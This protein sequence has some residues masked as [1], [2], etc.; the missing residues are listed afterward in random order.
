MWA[1]EKW[2]WISWSILQIF[3]P[4]EFGFS[5]ALY[6]F[7]GWQDYLIS[8][9]FD[10]FKNS[11][12]LSSFED[13]SDRM[14]HFLLKKAIHPLLRRVFTVK[15]LFFLSAPVDE[16]NHKQT[17]EET[18]KQ[19]SRKVSPLFFSLEHQT[20]F[21]HVSCLHIDANIILFKEGFTFRMND[22]TEWN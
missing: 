19:L 7:I 18:K 4:L 8:Y 6:V 13:E 12:S 2:G 15:S 22:W 1:I 20:S 14:F 11:L 16:E 17:L 21:Y 5:L 9:Y 3:P 10:V